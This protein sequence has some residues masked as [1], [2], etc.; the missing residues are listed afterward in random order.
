MWEEGRQIRKERKLN[1]FEHDYYVQTPKESSKNI[2]ELL[3]SAN[4]QDSK[5]T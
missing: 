2:L 3:S 5:L 1:L 4:S